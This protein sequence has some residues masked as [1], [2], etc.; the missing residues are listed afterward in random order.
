MRRRKILYAALIIAAP[1][2]IA[3][4]S[5]ITLTKAY[6]ATTA[7]PGGTVVIGAKAFSLD[8]ANDTKNE[9]EI[10]TAIVTGGNVYVKSY[11]NSWVNNA[12]YTSINANIL[13]S[14]TYKN[15][16]GIISS[17]AA[18]DT[19]SDT[20]TVTDPLEIINIE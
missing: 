6:G 4:L 9:S 14:V 8:Y 12:T 5:N 3:N 18:G 11:D 20:P 16:T 10:M 13:P 15:S 2:F 17:Y 7:M 19:S 1:L